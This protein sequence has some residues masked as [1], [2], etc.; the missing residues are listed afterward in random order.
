MKKLLTIFICLFISI[1]F[2]NS[3]KIN[4]NLERKVNEIVSSYNEDETLGFQNYLSYSFNAPVVFQ[5]DAYEF[6]YQDHIIIVSKEKNVLIENIKKDED[7]IYFDNIEKLKK[8]DLS[9]GFIAETKEYYAGSNKGGARYKIIN[10]NKP[11]SIPLDNGLFA[12]IIP[13]YRAFSIESLGVKGNGKDDDSEIINYIFQNVAQYDVS[14]LIFESKEYLCCHNINLYQNEN[15]SLLISYRYT[16]Y[17]DSEGKRIAKKDKVIYRNKIYSLYKEEK[18]WY[19]VDNNITE[20]IK[21]Q[22][23]VIDKEGKIKVYFYGMGERI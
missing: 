21:L 18:N 16:D 9:V 15:L 17:F 1:F 22:E 6:E 2:C 11:L 5:N 19:L 13:Q 4:N 3:C 10:D 20:K 12:E 23:A 14:Y 8:Q 7:I